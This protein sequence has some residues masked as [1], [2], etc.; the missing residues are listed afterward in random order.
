MKMAKEK[1]EY[2]KDI[3]FISMKKKIK[4]AVDETL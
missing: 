1:L 3:A 2:R 4:G